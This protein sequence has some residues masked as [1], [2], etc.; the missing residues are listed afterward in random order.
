MNETEGSEWMMKLQGS[1]RNPE[2]SAAYE[3]HDLEFVAIF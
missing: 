1:E 3:V 2:L